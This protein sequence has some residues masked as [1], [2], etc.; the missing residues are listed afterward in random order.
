VR[1]PSIHLWAVVL[2]SALAAT[3]M[4]CSGPSPT[5]IEPQVETDPT[6]SDSSAAP[7]VSKKTPL[8][9]YGL[10]HV[11][12][13]LPSEDICEKDES[14]G[15][16]NP[17]AEGAYQGLLRNAR[18]DQQK[19]ITMA[20]VAKALGVQ[21]N[22]CHVVDPKDP[23]KEIYPEFTDN[24]R[25]A[26][27]MFKTFVQGLRPKDGGNMMCAS[28]HGATEDNK[29]VPK[30]LK[31]PRDQDFAQEWMHEVMT[32][33]FVE[34]NGKRLKCKTCHVGM[35][36]KSGGWIKDVIRRLRY[37]DAVERR[38]DVANDVGE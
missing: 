34:K 9:E 36:P 32:V 4:S 14:G 7:F 12:V 29:S 27:W 1:S 11:G 8:A 17:I 13:E 15:L 35:A 18:C 2:G 26:N 5:P 30:L 24:K 21:C 23:K 25:V 19:F 20:R 37:K 6:P 33:N 31:E 16:K 22:H 28:C 3:S 10:E 38:S